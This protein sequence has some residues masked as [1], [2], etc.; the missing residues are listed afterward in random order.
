[1]RRC[2]LWVACCLWSIA[3]T[4]MAAQVTLSG[5]VTDSVSGLPLSG[6]ELG[7][8]RVAM[9]GAGGANESI[10]VEATAQ[11]NGSGQYSLSVDNALPD[12]D[13]V[14]VFTRAYD[15]LNELYNDVSIAGRTPT[16]AEIALAGV[17]AVDLRVTVPNVNLVLEPGGVGGKTT[18]MLE[19]RDGVTH[20]A[21]D[22]Y[23]PQGAGPWPVVLY[24]T[25]Y[26]KDSDGVAVWS[27]YTDAG[28]AVVTQDLRGTG[29]SEDIFRAFRDDGWG[30][31]QDGHDTVLWI[32][33]QTWC[34]GRI[35]TVGSSARGISQNMLSGSLP[36]GLE[37]QHVGVAASNMFTQAMF[38]GGGFL[39]A[40]AEGW[41]SG[42]GPEALNYLNT[43][44]KAHPLY[45][46]Y[47]QGANYETRFAQVDWPIVNRGGWYDIFLQG[48]INNFTGIQHNG[49]PGADGRQKLIIDP[50]GHGDGDGGFDWPPGCTNAPVAYASERAW[51]DYWIKGIN[52]GVM[53]E[54]A[55]CYYVLGDVDQPN[56]VGNEWRFADDWPVPATDVKFYL[57]QGGLLNTTPPTTN[58]TTNTYVYDPADPVP[59]YGGS[60]LTISRGP[61]DQRP[62]ENRTDVILFT[63]PVLQDYVE[64][65]G[66]V[67][68]RLYAASSAL[69]TDFTAKLCDVYP[70]G[71]S[72]NVCDGIIRARHRNS[73][74]YEELLTPGTIYEFEIDLWET[75]I[76]FAAGHRIR[77][78]ISSS[79][80]PRFE[81]NPNTGEPF[82][83]HTALLPATNTL[84][85]SRLY[86][87]HLLVRATGPDTNA[88]GL[89]DIADLDE[90]GLNDDVEWR[91][92]LFDAGD[93]LDDLA[94]VFA[95]GDFDA[96][97]LDN[98]EES[99]AGTDP[100]CTDTDGDGLN[101]GTEVGLGTDALNSASHPSMAQAYVNFSLPAGAVERGSAVNPFNSLDEALIV[102][103]AAGEIIF[104]GPDVDAW[105]GRITQSVRLRTT[106]GPVRIGG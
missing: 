103:T 105:Y 50:Y 31:N 83:Q 53:N 99:T 71:R 98:L 76:A 85:H 5:V 43:V 55:V 58:E 54:P 47:W 12:L 84:H 37:C 77:V 16:H 91:I 89:P 36:P 72:M 90:D 102:V 7:F 56:G 100:T 32:L 74:S 46:A 33:A 73:Q 34:D 93:D 20:I 64:I 17:V 81:I 92:I 30:E 24:R 10:A 69:D 88:D 66:K 2:L 22:V 40:L 104:L 38:Q 8:T 3:P 6:V 95:T 1:M 80:Y 79:N 106:G 45:D 23:L 60:N 28:Y 42:R 61:Y 86:P 49:Q 70:D 39:K 101:D 11:T 29:A 41:M 63:T 4:A 15:H 26:D 59:T 67:L 27:S 97:G 94:D 52:T 13:Q 68:V 87:S 19:M 21:T 35:G 75:C 18:Y 9:V 48:T 82:N 96:D 25:P 62:V 14:L 51:L 65:T 44:V 78:A 57:H